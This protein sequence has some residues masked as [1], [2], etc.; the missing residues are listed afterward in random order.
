MLSDRTGRYREEFYVP[1]V[2]ETRPRQAASSD[3]PRSRKNYYSQLDRWPTR[4]GTQWKLS[5]Q[6]AGLS[7]LAK[8]VQAQSEVPGGLA[9][10]RVV[11][12]EYPA[13]PGE[14]ILAELMRLLVLAE[15]V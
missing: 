9:C 4:S 8:A 7:F 2:L 12:T 14:R 6:L 10:I 3:S 11:V 1:G 5:S 15:I 13:P